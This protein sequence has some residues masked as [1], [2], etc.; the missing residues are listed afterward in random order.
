MFCVTWQGCKNKHNLKKK[1]L[2]KCSRKELW[3]PTK[4]VL[5]PCVRRSICHLKS[6]LHQWG[7]VRLHCSETLPLPSGVVCVVS[8]TLIASRDGEGSVQSTVLGDAILARHCEGAFA[9]RPREK[10]RHRRTLLQVS[11]PLSRKASLRP[12]LPSLAACFL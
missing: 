4:D 11:Q 1:L 12:D 8:G 10:Q 9:E 6:P 7:S 2:A 5:L 3:F